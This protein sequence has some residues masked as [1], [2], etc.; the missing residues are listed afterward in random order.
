[1]LSERNQVSEDSS[2][3]P[4]ARPLFAFME[5]LKNLSSIKRFGTLPMLE[6]ETVASHCFNVAF[7]A[8]LIADYEKD[9]PIDREVVL[10]KALMHDF[11]ETILSDIPHPIKHRF[12]GGKLGKLLKDLVPD[13][14]EQEIF[15]E[16]PDVLRDSCIRHTRDAKQGVEGEIVEAADAMDIVITSLREIKLGN[17]Y[18]EHIYEVG[19]KMLERHE[20]L[21][22]PRLFMEQAREYRLKGEH[23]Y[24]QPTFPEEFES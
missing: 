5:R 20:A 24:S 19:M 9:K 18:F 10:R 6:T 13:L 11:E 16:L 4:H 2:D 22:F 14:I 15:K 17:K 23:P 3:D 1:M 7:L 21:R 12:K 8:M